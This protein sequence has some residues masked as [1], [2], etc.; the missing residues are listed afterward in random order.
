MPREPLRL[1]C[2]LGKFR[3]VALA[4]HPVVGWSATIDLGGRTATLSIPYDFADIRKGDLLTLYTEIPTKEH[5]GALPQKTS[6][7]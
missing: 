4:R 6:D 2:I 1:R 7:N 5:I 3:C